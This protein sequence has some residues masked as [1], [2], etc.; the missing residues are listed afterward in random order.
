MSRG[1][2][3]TNLPREAILAA[4]AFTALGTGAIYMWSIFNK[5]LMEEFG[6]TTSEVSMIYSL[7][8]LASCFSSMLAGWLQRHTQPRFI[9]L[10]QVFYSALDGFARVLLTI[11]LCS[12]FFIVALQVPETVCFTT[13][14]L[15]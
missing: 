2:A 4:G 12:T 9:V 5:P 8:L 1:T 6:F 11:C 7:F 13:L 3:S 15:R 10:A 14:L